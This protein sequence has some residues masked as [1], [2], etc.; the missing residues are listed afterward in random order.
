M[1]RLACARRTAADLKAL[2]ANVSEAEAATK[3]GDPGRRAEIH[4]EFHSLL[5]RAA[6][7]PV[8]IILT[9]ALMEMTR[10]FVEAVGYQPNPYVM[11]SRKRLLAALRAK[12]GEAAAKE[13][14]SMLKRLQRFHLA[15]Y[16]ET[17]EKRK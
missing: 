3:A 8:L 6:K 16:E 4:Y 12:D 15:L 7:N 9:D 10:H 17:R 11:P 13:M 5:A 14:A 2:E 1:A